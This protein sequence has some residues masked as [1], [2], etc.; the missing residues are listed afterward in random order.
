MLNKTKGNVI[1]PKGTFKPPF[2]GG[3]KYYNFNKFNL[4][5]SFNKYLLTI[6]FIADTGYTTHWL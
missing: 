5:Y 3:E 4:L 1:F 6:Y 2:F